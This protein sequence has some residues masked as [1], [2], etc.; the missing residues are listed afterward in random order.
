MFNL[1]AWNWKVV[2]NTWSIEQFKFIKQLEIQASSKVSSSREFDKN[3]ASAISKA[4]F[5]Y[6]AY[7]N[8]QVFQQNLKNISAL[9]FL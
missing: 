6:F 4:E 1:E 8:Y 2:Y 5:A 7:Q 9:S 3:E